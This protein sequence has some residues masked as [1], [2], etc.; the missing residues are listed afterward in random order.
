MFAPRFSIDIRRCWSHSA[1]LF[2]IS[3]DVNAGGRGR[4]KGL[5]S[6][7]ATTTTASVGN[8]V[9]I[10]L[11]SGVGR[12][13]LDIITDII[14]DQTKPRYLQYYIKTQCIK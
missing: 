1:Q 5:C 4:V 13:V 10:K 3:T 14:S 9:T 2:R 7:P 12:Y 11:S 8:A 6:V